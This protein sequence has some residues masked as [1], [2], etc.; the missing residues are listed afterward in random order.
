MIDE[1]FRVQGN[2]NIPRG[3]LDILLAKLHAIQLE[4][5]ANHKEI[6][7]NFQHM[8]QKITSTEAGLEPVAN[9]MKTMQ[10]GLA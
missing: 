1:G 10:D 6:Q 2:T 8:D 5:T 9:D 3:T 4:T 7:Q